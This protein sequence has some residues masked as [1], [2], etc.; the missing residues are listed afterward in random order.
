MDVEP[1]PEVNV[2]GGV[3]QLLVVVGRQRIDFLVLV[4]EE[5]LAV[6]YGRQA[7]EHHV[8]HVDP[9]VIHHQLFDITIKTN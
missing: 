4:R 8:V 1:E 5:E 7:E 2:E 9:Q 6:L 3:R